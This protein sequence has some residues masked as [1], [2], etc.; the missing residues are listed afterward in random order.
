MELPT[1]N[2]YQN[3][4]NNLKN[5]KNLLPL[6]IL[7]IV[8]EGRLQSY[9]YEK[10]VKEWTNY[11]SD[12]SII[13]DGEAPPFFINQENI[14]QYPPFQKA[15]ETIEEAKQEIEI[16]FAKGEELKRKHQKNKDSTKSIER[17]QRP[18]KLLEE[19]REIEKQLRLLTAERTEYRLD[20]YRVYKNGVY[21]PWLKNDH[22]LFDNDP[23]SASLSITYEERIYDLWQFG[24]IDNI[25][26]WKEIKKERAAY[27]KIVNRDEMHKPENKQ[28]LDYFEQRIKKDEGYIRAIEEKIRNE[29]KDVPPESQTEAGEYPIIIEIAGKKWI[30]LSD[31]GK[32]DIV[33]EYKNNFFI[34]CAL[35]GYFHNGKLN[36]EI[37]DKRINH[38]LSTNGKCSSLYKKINA[39][40][41][42]AEERDILEKEKL[43]AQLKV[44]KNSEPVADKINEAVKNLIAFNKKHGLF[45]R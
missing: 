6:L 23:S 17:M 37:I 20:E 39:A 30:T 42:I 35:E 24:K 15:Y 22:R 2:D 7:E 12:K 11:N 41:K 9:E 32:Y 28:S 14:K 44:I 34:L 31:N 43:D 40:K 13:I 18:M 4:L 3:R 21:G 19:Y 36:L 45:D 27:N 33:D 26:A 25:Y 5:K 16:M 8:N 1:G 29:K 38:G 10:K